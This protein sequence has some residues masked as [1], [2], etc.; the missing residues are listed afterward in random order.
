M[1][2]LKSFRK[3]IDECDREIVAALEKRFNAV[4]DVVAYKKKNNL[5]ILQPNREKQVLE[6]IESYQDSDEFLDEIESIYI[7]IMQKS[8][9]LQ[10][11]D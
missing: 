2:D 3:T 7:Y 8:K 11:K 1:N 5:A 10:K 9:E 4:K 6:R